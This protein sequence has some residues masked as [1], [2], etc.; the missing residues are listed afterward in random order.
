VKRAHA[1]ALGFALLPLGALGACGSRTGLLVPNDEVE[2]VE[3]DGAV[4][5]VPADAAV[6]DD[7]AD[8]LPIIDTFVPDTPPPNICADA[9]NTLIYVVTEDNE[10]LRFDPGSATFSTI[11]LLQCPDARSPFSMAVDHEGVGY[12]LYYDSSG[13]VPGPGSIYR[14]DLTNARCEATAYVPGQAGFQSFGM[15]FSL[16]TDPDSGLTGESLY[17]ANDNN[18][19]DSTVAVT[20]TLGRI[21]PTTF[22]LAVVGNFAPTVVPAPELTSGSDGRLFGFYSPGYL[23]GIGN[24][25]TSAIVQ[26]DK[27]TAQVVAE[28]E[29][30]TV[31]QGSAWA[32]GIWGGDFYLFTAPDGTESIVTRYDPNTGA[33]TQVASYPGLITGAGVSTCAPAK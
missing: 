31:D 29:L 7:A 17:V 26:I 28:D 18:S 4:I 12:V 5:L 9:S 8:A 16:S 1:L 11:G 20:G 10:L 6:G 22:N 30:P 15:S 24:G 3:P 27:T 32:F 13:T 23:P 33:V 25:A 14:V 19:I 21:D 2:I